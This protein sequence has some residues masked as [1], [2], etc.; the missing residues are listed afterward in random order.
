MSQHYSGSPWSA[1]FH[2]DGFEG[3]SQWAI[4]RGATPN[5]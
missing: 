3:Y 5:R 2:P 1:V 4:P